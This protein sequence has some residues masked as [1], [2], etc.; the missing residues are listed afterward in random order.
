M[1]KLLY[2]IEFPV[3][4]SAAVQEKSAE[5]FPWLRPHGLSELGPG[6]VS[7]HRLGH[8]L[9]LHLEGGQIHR[10]GGSESDPN[11]H[12]CGSVNENILRLPPRFS[13]LVCFCFKQSDT[14]GCL[15]WFWMP[16]ID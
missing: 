8:V 1:M 10:K 3:R 11:L 5:D 15:H 14:V 13:A 9:L 16:R 6:P 4:A 7:A 12:I 2:V